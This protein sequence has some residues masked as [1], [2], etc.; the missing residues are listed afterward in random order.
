MDGVCN[1][2]KNKQVQ[3]RRS[4][5]GGWAVTEDVTISDVNDPLTS[6]SEAREEIREHLNWQASEH[7]GVKWYITLN[8]S[9]VRRNSIGEEV[10]HQ[11]TFRGEVAILLKSKEFE[12]LYNEQVELKMRRLVEFVQN[13]SGWSTRQVGKIVLSMVAYNPTGGSS[14]IG[15]PK[16]LI[17]KYVIVNVQDKDSKYFMWAVLS[18]LHPQDHHSERVAKYKEFA[19]ELNLAGL[20]F[21]LTV[22]NV[23]K[24]ESF[25]QTN[26][27]NVFAYKE[28][29]GVYRLH[30]VCKGSWSPYQ[31]TALVRKR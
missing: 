19:S 17:G 15:T 2:C 28:K 31:L 14:F 18:A 22:S 16:S 12:M 7:H 11:K 29:S 5:L 4:S 25:N 24:F 8:V 10:E 30:N 3:N 27:I 6:L 21:P 26:S 13:G 23:K 1:A 20:E 9:F